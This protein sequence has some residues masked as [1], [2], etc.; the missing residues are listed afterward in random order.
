MSP[1]SDSEVTLRLLELQLDVLGT[2][3]DATL[4]TLAVVAA[5]VIVGIAGECRSMVRHRIP[6]SRPPAD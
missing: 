1:Y 2:V 3:A 5:V 6:S 4:L